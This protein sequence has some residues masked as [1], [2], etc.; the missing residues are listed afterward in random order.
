VNAYPVI[1]WRNLL[2]ETPGPTVTHSADTVGYPFANLYDWRDYTQWMSSATGELVIKLD[3]EPLPGQVMTVDTLVIFG[4]DLHTVG[5]SGLSLL[6]SDDDVTYTP[7]FTPLTPDS[8][9]IIFRSFAEEAHRYFKLIIPAGY[10]QAPKIGLLF[11]G[12]AMAIPAY[13]DSGFDPDALEADVAAEYSRTG[14]LLGIADRFRRR[15]IKVNFSRLPLAFI[16]DELMPF[17]NA[18]GTKPWFFAWDPVGHPDEAYLVRLS[19]PRLEAP[20]EKTLRNLSLT[21]VATEQI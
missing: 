4:H 11:V 18:H 20:Y 9:R 14:R 8:D 16:K 19:T 12:A 17:W 3:A 1:A 13:P 7:C 5:V 15:E 10:T 6:W 21:L 2:C